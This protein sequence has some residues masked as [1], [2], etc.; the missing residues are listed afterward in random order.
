[1]SPYGSSKLM[2][3][4]MLR[5][6]GAAHGLDARDPAL[7]QRRRRRS[8]SCAPASRPR[9]RRISSRSRS[10]PRSASAPKMRGLRH[11]L[12]DAGRHLHPRLHPRQRSRAR[13][14]RRARLSARRRRLGH[15]QLRL[16]PRLLGARGDRHGQARVGRRFPGRHARRARP[17]DPAQIVAKSDRIRATARLAAAVR[18]SRPPSSRHALAWERKLAERCDRKMTPATASA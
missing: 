10:R 2:T 14:F 8:R 11:R 1:M 6:A 13:A 7:L 18:R 9:A 5:D 17:G 12:S 16:R 15:A 4:I 3:E